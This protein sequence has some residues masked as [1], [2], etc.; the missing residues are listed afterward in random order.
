MAKPG[1]ERGSGERRQLEQW[2]RLA[3]IGVEF[4][5]SLLLFGGIGWWVDGAAGTRPWGMIAG[6]LLGFVVGLWLM[7][8][9][10][11]GSFHD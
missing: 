1:E 3:G 11:S 10:A 5:V 7:L 6:A 8:K 2:Y 4:V 9:A